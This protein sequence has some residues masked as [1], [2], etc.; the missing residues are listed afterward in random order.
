MDRCCDEGLHCV[1]SA[2][3]R[4]ESRKILE[5]VLLDTSK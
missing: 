5:R 1:Q 3:S 4:F 2:R